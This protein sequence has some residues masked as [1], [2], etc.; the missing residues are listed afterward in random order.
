MELKKDKPKLTALSGV[1]FFLI[2]FVA[3]GHFIEPYIVALPKWSHDVFLG[4]YFSTSTFFLLSGF[5][6]TYVYFDRS[7]GIRISDKKFWYLRLV[8]LYPVHL[9]FLLLMLPRHL[10]S[11]DFGET[12]KYMV[13]L[14]Q[15][16]LVDAWNPK[17]QSV[18]I[19]AW[20]ISALLFFYLIFPFFCRYIKDF[21]ITRLVKTGLFLWGVYLLYPILYTV[22]GLDGKIYEGILHHNPLIRLPE[23]LIG[24]VLCRLFVKQH[25]SRLLHTLLGKLRPI[26]VIPIVAAGYVVMCLSLP[27]ALLHNGMFLP[28]QVALVL[29]LTKESDPLSQFLARPVVARLG[30]ASLT[31]FIGHLLLMSWWSRV[32]QIIQF[33][34]TRSLAEWMNMRSLLNNLLQLRYQTPGLLSLPSF[35]IGLAVMVVICVLIQEYFVNPVGRWLQKLVIPKRLAPQPTMVVN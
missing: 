27:Y 13:F 26:S 34:A 24:V 14:S 19:A 1:R 25:E 10:K 35:F 7:A 4:Y 22:L 3:I 9:L 31:I 28:L 18:N 2:M 8:R 29:A 15:L 20:S 12:E 16:L 30:N 17:L 6:L 5:I 32:D 11:P 21:T 33:L 23:F